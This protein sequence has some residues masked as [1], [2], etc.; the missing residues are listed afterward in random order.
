MFLNSIIMKPLKLS[1]LLFFLSVLMFFSCSK[2]EPNLPKI[3]PGSFDGDIGRAGYYGVR[4]FEWDERIVTTYFDG[5]NYQF[6]FITNQDLGVSSS[7]FDYD[8]KHRLT[9]NL[10]DPLGCPLFSCF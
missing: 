1:S 9:V 5:M 3:E 10:T 7:T 4:N 6:Q 2:D 8:I